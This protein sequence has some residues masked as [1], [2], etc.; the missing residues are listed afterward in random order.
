[1]GK[2]TTDA[3][4]WAAPNPN[5]AVA[6]VPLIDPITLQGQPIPDRPWRVRGWIPDLQVTMVSGDGGVGKSLVAQ[7]LLTACATGNQWLGLD[8]EPCKCVAFF[9]EDDADEIHR[10]QVRI[11]ESMGLELGDLEN[12]AW[13]SMVA[14]DDLGRQYDYGSEGFS[15]HRPDIDAEEW[16]GIRPDRIEI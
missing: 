7:Q 10:R 4:D 1:M 15:E 16:L 14:E 11:N 9:A 8:V 12:M 6:A 5:H 3:Q 13:A 2:V